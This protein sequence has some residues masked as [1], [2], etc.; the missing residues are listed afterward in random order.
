MKRALNPRPWRQSR[1]AHRQRKALARA[2]HQLA[3]LRPQWL[4][5]WWKH[6]KSPLHY[7]APRPIALPRLVKKHKMRLRREFLRA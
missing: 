1:D 3:A 7:R 2:R 4:G 5:Q 6:Q